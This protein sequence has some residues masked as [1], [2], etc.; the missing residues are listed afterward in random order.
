MTK[1]QIKALRFSLF[2]VNTPLSHPKQV[3]Q[4]T[5]ALDAVNVKKEKHL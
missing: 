1:D 4:Q 3:G 5:I 2:G